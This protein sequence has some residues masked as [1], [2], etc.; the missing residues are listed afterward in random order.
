LPGVVAAPAAAGGAPNSAII[1]SKIPDISKLAP[2]NYE[3]VNV[4]ARRITAS[5]MIDDTI[6][7]PLHRC[8][9]ISFLLIWRPAANDRRSAIWRAKSRTSS[10]V[11]TALT[12][13][14]T[15][16][17]FLLIIT[18]INCRLQQL[19]NIVEQKGGAGGGVGGGGALADSQKG[20]ASQIRGRR[21][22]SHR[23]Y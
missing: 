15:A 5:T 13:N 1:Y 9:A 2:V 10:L 20:L 16:F 14:D 7:K 22:D 23:R 8:N 21:A 12:T 18:C 3:E 6:L 19:Y 4:V 11:A 17:F